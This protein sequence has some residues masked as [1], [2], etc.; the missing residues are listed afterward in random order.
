MPATSSEVNP[1]VLSVS[2]R[3][4]L[5]RHVAGL[6]LEL[7]ALG[8]DLGGIRFGD[9]SG[10]EQRLE[11]TRRIVEMAA[12]LHVPVMTTHLGRFDP[13]ARRR[14]DLA[15]V[16]RE[17]ADMADRTGTFVAFETGMPTRP[18]WPPS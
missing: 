14:G 7:S 2:G 10:L 5:Q 18:R 6:G 13:E 16:V 3:R 8:G 4:H 12:D 17:L 9:S 15:A 1:E 11:R